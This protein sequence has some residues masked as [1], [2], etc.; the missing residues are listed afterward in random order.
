MTVVINASPTAT[1]SSNGPLCAGATLNLSTPA[2]TGNLHGLDQIVYIYCQN[3]TIA[4]TASAMAG[5]YTVTANGGCTV[6]L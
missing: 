2:V 1:A 6:L 5:T 3:P 4:S